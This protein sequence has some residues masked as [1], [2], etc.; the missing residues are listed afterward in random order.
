MRNRVSR[1]T[2]L[3]LGS[4]DGRKVNAF[5]VHSEDDMIAI[6]CGLNDRDRYEVFILRDLFPEVR[7]VMDLIEARGK[8]GAQ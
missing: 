8:A 1:K 2:T 6:E 4:D 5:D 3:W 7:R